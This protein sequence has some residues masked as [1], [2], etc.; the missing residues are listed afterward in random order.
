[1]LYTIICLAMIGLVLWLASY[2]QAGVPGSGAS[3]SEIRQVGDFKSVTLNAVADV[4][5]SSGDKVQVTITADDNILPLLKTTVQN[6]TL[7]IGSIQDYNS[8]SGVKIAIT[9]PSICG[10]VLNG[11]GDITIDQVHGDA[12]DV[13]LRGSG[14]LLAR[15]NSPKLSA[16]LA[17]VG[18][19]NLSEWASQLVSVQMSG[20]GSAK[21]DASQSLDA[22]L[23]GVG[24]VQY[25]NHPSL[26]LV[27]HISGVGN[28]SAM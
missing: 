1:M 8:K 9:M 18:N 5:I 2:T 19:L 14:T 21:V 17:G 20:S 26:Q 15:G 25:K 27:T 12:L 7:Q 23:S 13:Q 4:S 22:T 6:G 28:I 11:V 3:R 10:I 16:S 24:N